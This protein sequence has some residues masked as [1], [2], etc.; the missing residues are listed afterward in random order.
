MYICPFVCHTR[1]LYNEAQNLLFT[2]LPLGSLR[3]SSS[4]TEEQAQLPLRNGASTAIYF[5]DIFHFRRVYK[6]KRKRE[7]HS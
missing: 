7:L 6:H 4:F 3:H 2:I 5:V 1:G